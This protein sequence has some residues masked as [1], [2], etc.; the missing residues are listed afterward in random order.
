MA[1]SDADAGSNSAACDK[2]RKMKLK[3]LLY[4]YV[5][6]TNFAACD[7]RRK[8]NGVNIVVL[9]LSVIGMESQKQAL[10]SNFPYF[11]P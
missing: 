5:K 11:V 3:H 2:R 8:P 4:P 10:N 6:V 7:K 9:Q 1:G